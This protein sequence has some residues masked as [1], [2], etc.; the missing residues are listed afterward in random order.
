MGMTKADRERVKKEAEAIKEKK[1]IEEAMKAD[2][3][4]YGEPV[5]PGRIIPPQGGTGVVLAAQKP[6]QKQ[7]PRPQKVKPPVV[8]TEDVIVAC[9]HTAK[10]ELFAPKQDKFRDARRE[11]LAKRACPECRQ[12]THRERMEQ[13]KVKR[14]VRAVRSAAF[15]PPQRLPTGS[16][17][18]LTWDGELWH[19]ILTIPEVGQFWYE[20]STERMCFHGLHQMWR[21]FEAA[22]A[23]ESSEKAAEEVAEKPA[24]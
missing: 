12:K 17:K 14:E 5:P 16:V 2:A 4:V 11:K 20:A 18:T 8:G 10:L 7:A 15:I 1:K 24:E 6:V 22:K 9:G 13:D 19:G 21:E 3:G 23:K